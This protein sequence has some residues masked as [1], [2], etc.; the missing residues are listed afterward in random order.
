MNTISLYNRELRAVYN[1]ALDEEII[2]MDKRPFRKSFTGQE[3]TRKRA[4]DGGVVKRLAILSLIDKEMLGFARD[5][6]LFSIYMQGMPF[7]D[8]AYL[9]KE[10]V[11]NGCITYQ[12]RKTNRQLRVKIHPQAQIIIDRYMVSDPGCPYL[13]PILYDPEKRQNGSIRVPCVSITS[14]WTAF[15]PCWNWT[16]R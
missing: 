5:L 1:Y 16:S 8:M 15:P 11:R 2:Q 6:F 7:I 9:K 13:F 12:R 4:V 3:K 10:Q 14:V